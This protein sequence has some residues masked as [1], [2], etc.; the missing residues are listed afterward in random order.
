MDGLVLGPLLRYVG[1]TEATVWVE[2]ARPCE[3]EVLGCRAS[4]FHVE[5]HHYALV[6]VEGLEPGS[7]T[8]YDVRL[9]GERAWPLPDDPFPAPC[10]RPWKKGGPVR[11]AFGSCRVCAPHRE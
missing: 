3:V 5:D 10:I 7:E 4:T 6:R 11:V 2:T 8:P 9:D 1:E